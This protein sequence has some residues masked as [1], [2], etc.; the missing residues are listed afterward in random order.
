MR[1]IYFP[2][3][4]YKERYTCQLSAPDGW[5]QSRWKET[6]HD[7]LRIEGESLNKQIVTGSVLDGCGRGY[8]SCSQIQEFLYLLNNGQISSDDVLYFDDFWTPGIEALPY[9]FHLTGIKPKMYSLL[10][11]QSVD[12]YDFTYPMSHWMRDF[13]KG[14]G[15]CMDGIFVTST[16]LKNLLIEAGIG[17]R[18]NIVITGLPYNVNKVN[19]VV[20]VVNA[21]KKKR[22]VVFSSRWDWEKN[23]VF[24][25][26]VAQY[27]AEADPTIKFVITTSHEKLK[28]NDEDLLHLLHC[29][30][31]YNLPNLEL[32]ENQTK[33]QYYQTLKESKIQFNCAYQDFVSWTLLEAL[34]YKCLPVYPN[35][36]SFPEVL[37]KEYLYDAFVVD[38]AINKIKEMLV[39]PSYNSRLIDVVLTFDLSWARMLD[40]MQYGLKNEIEYPLF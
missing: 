15:K 37:P 12:Q 21:K 34:T 17:S 35:F 4:P 14:I 1:I 29:I 26:N 30:D 19:E 3:E 38:S 5:L 11:A 23:P 27:F 25:L 24:F 18:D 9:A 22:Q 39:R 13:E 31:R 28:S 36:R 7:V 32:R 6:G 8:Y 20:P 2:L 40:F 33:E 10:H 16:L